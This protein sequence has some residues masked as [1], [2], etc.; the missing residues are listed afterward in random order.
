MN[1]LKRFVS[2]ADI[3]PVENTLVHMHI[4]TFRELE[5][6]RTIG[7]VEDIQSMKDQ[8]L[9]VRDMCKDYYAIGTIEEFK[10]LKEKNEPKKI[11]GIR[12]AEAICPSCLTELYETYWAFGGIHY[13][14][15]CGQKIDWQ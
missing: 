6:Y 15:N 7:T 14:S 9:M 12:H 5:Q 2:N 8:L 13:C 3:Q 10:A 1:D 11:K 4:E